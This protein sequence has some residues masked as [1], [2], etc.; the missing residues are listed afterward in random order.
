MP[1]Y[2]RKDGRIYTANMVEVSGRKKREYKYFGRGPEARE[3]AETYDA[4]ARSVATLSDSP[5]LNGLMLAYLQARQPHKSTAQ[6]I[7][8]YVTEFGIPFAEKA[9]SELNRV[10]L[11]VLRSRMAQAG[12]KPSTINKAY[13]YIRAILQWG[14]ENGLL[15]HNPWAGFKRIKAEPKQWAVTWEDFQAL[16]L[17]APPWL[18]WAMTVAYY[19]ALR[20]GHVELFGLQWTAF[21]FHRRVARVRQAKSGKIKAVSLADDFLPLAHRRYERDR[22]SSFQLVCHRGDGRRIKDYRTAWHWT[23]KRAGLE[24]SGIRFYDLRHLTASA[25]LAEGNDLVTTS[26]QMGHASPYVTATIYSHLLSDS[27]RQAANSLPPLTTDRC[28]QGKKQLID[29]KTK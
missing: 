14:V 20:P 12:R 6:S 22:E 13:A 4:Q 3:A 5:T 16:F 9:A 1:V 17:A 24:N 18:Q 29:I 19:L 23:R 21:D 27:Q 11:E 25:Y 15:A 2:T 10:D 26:H 28:C 8:K 7:I